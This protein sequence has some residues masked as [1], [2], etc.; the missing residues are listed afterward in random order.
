ME[1]DG[2][3][4]DSD[5]YEQLDRQSKAVRD[6]RGKKLASGEYLLTWRAEK[7]EWELTLKKATKG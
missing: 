3:T 5:Q 4:L 2:M 1:R 7:H 6:E